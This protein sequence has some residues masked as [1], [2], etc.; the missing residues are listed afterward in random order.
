[1][2]DEQTASGSKP[3]QILQ[4]IGYIKQVAQNNEL[5]YRL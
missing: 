3:K 1:L 2:S 5:L 4:L